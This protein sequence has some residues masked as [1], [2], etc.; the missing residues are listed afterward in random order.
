MQQIKNN[1]DWDG[2][3]APEAPTAPENLQQ[4][5]L[6]IGFLND[7]ILRTLYTRGGLLGLDLAKLLCL[8]FKVIEESLGFLKNEKAVEILGGDLIGRIS[9]R[10]NLTDL[11]RRRA[12]EA[13]KM[14]AYVGPAPVPLEDY[15]EQVYR[16]AVTAI[17]V[18][19]EAIKAAFGHLVIS[20]ELLNAVGP[21]I[22]SGK[23]VFIYG[24]PGNGK[25]A[26]TQSI[27]SFMNQCGGEIYVPYAF[28]TEN[29][30]ITIFDKAVHE[31]VDGDDDRTEDNEA[32]IR[33][34]LNTGAVDPRW[35]KIKR[36]VIITGGELNL[37]ML[38]LRF[39]PE[40]NYYQA[41]LHVKA[42]GGIFL[43]D[44]FGR[45]LCS[46]KE[47][48][49]RWIVPLENRVDYLSLASGQQFQVPF[50][51]LTM[52]STN[53]DPKDLV[54]EAFL[55]RMRHKVEITAPERDIYEK[56]FNAVVKKLGM[57]P[58]PDAVSFLYDRYYSRGRTPRASD[59]RDLLETVQSICRFRRVPVQLT[60]DLM[61]EAAASFIREFK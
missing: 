3:G 52:F 34:L 50:E 11:G 10:F 2:G 17:N 31:T 16:Q 30:V 1:Y 15:V 49:N 7:M 12:Q 29:N 45:Q 26:I 13:L 43:V 28:M 59:A 39:N 21:A 46:P 35:V 56:I 57:S 27:G 48:L 5:G 38:D 20:D 23:S 37:Q 40:S 8:P 53:L 18:S 44:D 9:Y 32:T 19:P 33:R 4:T 54:D 51:Q 41:P 36:P 61:A 25:T 60:R 58:C 22:V 6:T 24:P 14:C 42:N 47:L 55:R